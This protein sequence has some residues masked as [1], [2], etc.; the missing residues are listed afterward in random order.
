[1]AFKVII[2]HN[3]GMDCAR[4]SVKISSDPEDR[5]LSDAFEKRYPTI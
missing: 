5:D 2:G 4:K 1:M 3:S